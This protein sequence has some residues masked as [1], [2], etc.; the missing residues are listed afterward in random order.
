MSN[1]LLLEDFLE[2]VRMRG[3]RE[4]TIVTSKNSLNNFFQVIDKSCLGVSLPELKKY[5]NWLAKRDGIMGRKTITTETIRKYFNNLASFYEYLEFEEHIV[6]SP[7]PKFRRRYLS[8]ITKKNDS[9]KRQL[10]SVEKMSDLINSLLDPQEKAFFC[11]LAKTGVRAGELISI[12]LDDI[13]WKNYS[14]KLKPTGKRSNLIVYFDN[15]CAKVLRR[16]INT[17]ESLAA[18]AETA[19]FINKAKGDRITYHIVRYTV[20]KHAIRLGLHDTSAG[21][22]QRFGPH[23]FRHWFTTHLRRFGMPRE[24][25]KELRA[26]S[27]SETI[28]IYDHIDEE[29]LRQAYLANIPQLGM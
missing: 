10:I 18:K 23:C 27:R 17:R 28:D 8:H 9:S 3:W 7:I 14:I 13:N 15:E 4:S 1:E 22:E 29:E 6:R 5:L 11:I 21:L 24:Y 19:L 26:D 25:I 16:W 2:D 20:N 12:D